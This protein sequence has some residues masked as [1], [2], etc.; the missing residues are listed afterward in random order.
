MPYRQVWRAGAG[1]GE[2]SRYRKEQLSG[3]P[4]GQPAPAGGLFL[5]AARQLPARAS[6]QRGGVINTACCSG[7]SPVTLCFAQMGT[8]WSA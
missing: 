1:Q 7:D 2:K 6:K 3:A 5:R 4:K 8:N